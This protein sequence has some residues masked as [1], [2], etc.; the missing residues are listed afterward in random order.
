MAQTPQQAPIGVSVRA[1]GVWEKQTPAYPLAQVQ[2]IVALHGIAVFGVSAIQGVVAMGLSGAQ[3]MAAIAALDTGCFYKSMTA[4]NDTS[5]TLWQDVYR[6]VTPVGAAYV[7][8]MVWQP[9]ARDSRTA[10]PPPKLVISFKR[11]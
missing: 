4:E 2:Q 11:L 5:K 9:P 3:A 10:R 6:A 1:D 8:F 7:K